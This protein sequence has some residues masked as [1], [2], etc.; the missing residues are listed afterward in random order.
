M[1]AGKRALDTVQVTPT[2]DVRLA[3]G[4]PL[5]WPSGECAA[6]VLTVGRSP[7]CDI[8][9][10]V[11]NISGRL[12]RLIIGQKGTVVL[13]D[14]NSTNGIFH[15][16]YPAQR[17][18][19][20]AIYRGMT[21]YFGTYQVNV[22]SLLDAPNVVAAVA[23]SVK[24]VKRSSDL[25]ATDTIQIQK[26]VLAGSGLSDRVQKVQ[27][28]PVAFGA[29]AIPLILLTIY[30]FRGEDAP[31]V[32][33]EVAN[34]PDENRTVL[35][36]NIVPRPPEVPL[37]PIQST[38]PADSLYW[39]VVE[40]KADKTTYRIGTGVAVGPRRI[41]TTGSIILAS[42]Q[43]DQSKNCVVQLIHLKSG[44]RQSVS[45]T[46]I[47]PEF[48]KRLLTYGQINQKL[49]EAENSADTN[50]AKAE[51]VTQLTNLANLAR[52]SMAAVDIG[53]I[54][55]DK[56][57]FSLPIA[58]GLTL[59]PNQ[60]LIAILSGLP[61]DDPLFDSEDERTTVSETVKIKSFGPA[62]ENFGKAVRLTAPPFAADKN[63]FG[64]PLVIRGKLA[65][66]I[67]R[68]ELDG[69]ADTAQIESVALETINAFVQSVKQ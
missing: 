13:E 9:L 44:T 6:K 33:A 17:L 68:N 31:T 30:A 59:R 28:L 8:V 25:D 11:G 51:D 26:P 47:N 10:D 63:L 37:P 24:S 1:V 21:V 65:G 67:C 39:I 55:T 45:A 54:E 34:L 20:L 15:E 12:A 40:T 49:D 18:R 19:R 52:A 58:S 16:A 69:D 7:D 2:T 22:A 27:W 62:V 35:E 29:I 14:T 48:S 32:K 4:I 60:D 41:L 46:G 42:Q 56:T 23:A 3:D 61:K 43:I 53:W 5:P 64:C 66:I 50:Q 36:S 57:E 38:G